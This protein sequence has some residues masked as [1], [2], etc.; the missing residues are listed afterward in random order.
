LVDDQIA[1]L[2]RLAR[3]L[4]EQFRS[5]LR[6]VRELQGLP[7]DEREEKV[8]E[9]LFQSQARP[10]EIQRQVEE[11]L[12]PH[13]CQRLQQLALQIRLRTGGAA[14]LLTVPEISARLGITEEQRRKLVQLGEEKSRRLQVEIE[15]RREQAEREL[16]DEVLLPEQR[17]KIDQLIGAPYRPAMPGTW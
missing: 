3:E 13:Q 1:R 10:H 14:A 9:L 7:D 16:L 15:R 17:A 8:L 5:R 4:N 2:E 11:I 6:S 12:L